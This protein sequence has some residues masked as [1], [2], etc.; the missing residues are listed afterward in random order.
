MS[1]YYID[2]QAR[3]KLEILYN[4]GESLPIIAKSLGV[5]LATVYRELARGNTGEMDANGREGYKAAIAQRAVIESFKRRG[6]RK[7]CI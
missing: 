7:K 5:H 1:H 4:S 3:V 2:Y 6:K